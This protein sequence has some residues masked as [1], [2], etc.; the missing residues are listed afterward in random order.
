MG[1]PKSKTL[2]KKISI[3]VPVDI[4]TLL[5]KHEKQGHINRSELISR[6]LTLH[7][8]LMSQDN[9]VH[10][11]LETYEQFHRDSHVNYI[12]ALQQFAQR[13]MRHHNDPDITPR[14]EAAQ[15]RYDEAKKGIGRLWSGDNG[16]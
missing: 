9:D 3:D 7:L 11:T 1:R 6:I 8:Y 12:W 13:C 15:K 16:D 5:E 2:K 10:E 14:V 4:L